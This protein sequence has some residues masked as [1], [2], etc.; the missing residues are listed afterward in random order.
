MHPLILPT[1]IDVTCPENSNVSVVSGPRLT[2]IITFDSTGYIIYHTLV[3]L[4]EKDYVDNTVHTI[5][6]GP[7]E[8]E[9]KKKKELHGKSITS[10]EEEKMRCSAS[11][12]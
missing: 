8:R 11:M 10:F 12:N 4:K 3:L 9:K 6:G 1:Q 5:L 2:G 7:R